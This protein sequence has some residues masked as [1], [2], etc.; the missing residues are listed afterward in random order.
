[1]SQPHSLLRN[2]VNW[3]LG[4]AFVRMSAIWFF[5]LMYCMEIVPFEFLTCSRKKWYFIAMCLVH[6]R[7]CGFV[8]SCIQLWLS[9]NTVVLIEISFVGSL[10]KELNSFSKPCKGMSTRMRVLNAM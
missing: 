1:M 7:Y 2:E 3:S 10:R 8:A 5:V 9:S 4:I 6:C